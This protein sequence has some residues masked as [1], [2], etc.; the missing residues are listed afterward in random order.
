MIGRLLSSHG[1]DGQH[2]LSTFMGHF[3][4]TKTHAG[5]RV[6]ETTAL[7]VSSIFRAADLL[8][9]IQAMMPLPVIK[10]TAPG[11]REKDRTHPVWPLLNSE[12]NPDMS[13]M[14]LRR[15]VN[16]HKLLWGNGRIE[17]VRGFRNVPMALELLLPHLATTQRGDDGELFYEVQE[18][19][20][21]KIRKIQAG[22]V[23]HI[24]GLSYDGIEGY[25]LI[26][27]LAK[28]DVG[29]AI[30]ISQYAQSFFGN[31][32]E[33][34]NILTS[35]NSLKPE[36]V[37]ELKGEWNAA[38]QGS[39][40]AHGTA[41]FGEGITVSKLGSSNRDAEFIKTATFSI[42]D[43]ARWLNVQPPFLME[44]SHGTFSN[45]REQSVWLL[46][47]S[48]APWLKTSEEEFTR[49]L[50]TSDEKKTHF[51]EYNAD[52]ILRGDT[53]ARMETYDIGLR[54]GIWSIDEVRARENLNPLP[55]GV[56]SKH[57]V[58]LNMGSLEDGTADVVQNEQPATDDGQS[59]E[60][61]AAAGMLA[62]GFTEAKVLPDI[63]E[64]LKPI[65][66]TGSPST[67]IDIIAAHQPLLADTENR[68]LIQER[69]AAKRAESRDGGIEAWAPEFYE[70]HEIKV[71]AAL[72]PCFEALAGSV[73]AIEPTG[74][75]SWTTLVDEGIDMAVTRHC[76]RSRLALETSVEA[77]EELEPAESI[78]EAFAD[79]LFAAGRV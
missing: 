13:A 10:E 14:S 18:G 12:P 37:K 78:A 45:I 1:T 66:P 65:Q 27:H 11:V 60:E 9:S 53:K 52:G 79:E 44:L 16:L 55:G 28:Q 15:A 23:I 74:N 29:L 31:N 24:A 30:A 51:V 64:P 4:G 21:L 58:P 26:R 77:L 48:L 47:Y 3:G 76:D 46:R 61:A 71:R 34:G 40:K 19:P 50:F 62:M 22:N 43:V 35:P 25:G 72:K 56:G 75:G 42:Q 57:R 7:S 6:N 68:M 73:Y 59:D 38:H 70:K 36:R 49:K 17:I 2:F 20:G 5:P 63:A 33:I 41:V 8:A 39:L 32:T 54:T 67:R 69:N